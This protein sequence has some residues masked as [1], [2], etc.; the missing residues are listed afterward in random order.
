MFQILARFEFCT[1]LLSCKAA[2]AYIFAYTKYV[3][4]FL[5]KVSYTLE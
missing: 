5:F 4:A 3:A 1:A 2:I